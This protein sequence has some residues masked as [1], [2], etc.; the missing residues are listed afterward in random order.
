[1]KG[2]AM[3]VRIKFRKYGVLKYVGHLDLMRFFQKMIRRAGLDICYSKG[4]NPHQIMSFAAPLGVGMIS[5]GE[6]LDIEVNSTESS[7]A[8]LLS[9]NAA[10]G[11]E[12]IE[13][14][15]YR[16]LSDDAKKAMAIVSA[17]DYI[18]CWNDEAAQ[19]PDASLLETQIAEYL[20]QDSI[21]VV[22]Q[23]KKKE[24]IIDIRPLI[25][26]MHPAEE[27]GRPGIF[28]RL[29]AGSAANIKPE[30]LLTDFCRF[31]GME[32]DPYDFIRKRLEVYA[33]PKEELTPLYEMG[34]EIV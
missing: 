20:K 2:Y 19:V 15:E 34:T 24:R 32:F 21:E 27:N 4:F 18:Y 7:A 28:M 30:L 16:R 17:A 6:Y 10:A 22:K 12:G 26:E 8:S 5:D 9:L 14:T 11:V 1:M 33:G 25:Y 3:K 13:L 23:G 29:S 31:L